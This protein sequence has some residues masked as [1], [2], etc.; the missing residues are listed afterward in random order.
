MSRTTMSNDPTEKS[1]LTRFVAVFAALLIAVSVAA[2]G[3]TSSDTASDASSSEEVVEETTDTTD[4]TDTTDTTDDT[5]ST[6]DA[7][8]SDDQQAAVSVVVEIDASAA[9]G[10]T[11]I[12]GAELDEGATAYDAL[13]EV[14]DDVNASET[15]Y[16]IYVQGINGLAE[17]DYGSMSGW[18]YSVNGEMAEVG[19]SEYVLEDGDVVIWT[20]TTDYSQM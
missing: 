5:D 12:L 16:G 14:A 15:D 9:E 20:Y 3:S 7:D 4:S 19:C 6:D 1:W 17:G 18:L 10:E 13:V 2:C 8:S 11:L